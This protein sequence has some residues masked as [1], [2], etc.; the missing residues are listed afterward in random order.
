MPVQHVY[1]LRRDVNRFVAGWSLWLALFLVQMLMSMVVDLLRRGY[2][3]GCLEQRNGEFHN[4]FI[5]PV[6]GLRRGGW[7]GDQSLSSFGCVLF[8]ARQEAVVSRCIAT[9]IYL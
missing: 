7:R 5:V 4:R 1:N 3:N 2:H 9:T 6:I 8:V